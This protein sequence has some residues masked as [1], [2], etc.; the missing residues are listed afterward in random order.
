MQEHPIFRKS[1]KAWARLEKGNGMQTVGVIGLGAMGL[2]MARTL[3]GKGFAVTAYDLSPAALVRAQEAGLAVATTPVE[4]MQ[5]ADVIVLSLPLARHVQETIEAGLAAGVFDGGPKIV[6]DTST[7]E[8][9]VSRDLAERLAAVGHGFLDAPVSG[10]PQGAA[11]GAL[12]VMIGG[13]AEWV[14]RVQ[15]VLQAL[16]A[17]VVHVGPSG[18]GNIAKLANNMLVACHMLTTAEALRMA[19]AAGL[20]AADALRV[21]NSATGRS[22]LSEVHFPKWVLTGAFDSGFSAGLMRKDVRLALELAGRNGC[23]MPV[24]ELVADLWSEAR[25]GLGDADDFMRI[26]DLDAQDVKEPQNG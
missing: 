14:A 5:A 1:F 8:A 21:I 23:N 4:V 13:D 19:Q 11:T 22:A 16:A 24:S 6:I 2:G 20:P 3:A 17:T 10:G 9:G 7:S 26:G 25:S 15:P 18:A 12:S